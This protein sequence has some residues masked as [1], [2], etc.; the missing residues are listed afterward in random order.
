MSMKNINIRLNLNK[1][2]DRKEYDQHA[3]LRTRSR[4][5]SAAEVHVFYGDHGLL[6]GSDI[7]IRWALWYKKLNK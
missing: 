7:E 6:Y 1:E 3:N 4:C 2:N 5:D